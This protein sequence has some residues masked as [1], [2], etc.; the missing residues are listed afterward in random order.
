MKKLL[1]LIFVLIL[2]SCSQEFNEQEF[3]GNEIVKKDG[4]VWHYSSTEPLTGK[5]VSFHENGQIKEVGNYINGEKDGLHEVFHEN[6]KLHRR[7]N[8]IN[9]EK[10]GLHEEYREDGMRQYMFHWKN[11]ELDGRQEYFDQWGDLRLRETCE[12]G[13]C[14]RSED[15]RGYVGDRRYRE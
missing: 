11:G 6:S 7:G 1:I 10:D 9:G 8:Y 15:Q 14:V 12:D 2:S 5:V 13:V 4:L 3:N